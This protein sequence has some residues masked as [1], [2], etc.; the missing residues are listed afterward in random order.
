MAQLFSLIITLL[1]RLVMMAFGTLMIWYSTFYG[2]ILLDPFSRQ[3]IATNHFTQAETNWIAL[4]AV[5]AVGIGLA[6]AGILLL[7]FGLRGLWRR[8]AAGMPSEDERAE[9]T[10]GRIGSAAIFGAG[11]LLGLLRLS[12]LVYAVGDQTVLQWTGVETTAVVERKWRGDWAPPGSDEPPRVAYQL[13]VAFRA[14]DGTTVRQEK[15]VSGVYY[16][17]VEEGSSIPITYASRNPDIS[18]L[19]F[20][21]LRRVLIEAVVWIGLISAGLWGV[22]RNIGSNVGGNA[23]HRPAPEKAPTGT[24]LPPRGDSG[25]SPARR[26]F[27]QRTL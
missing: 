7:V 25:G 6:V 10:T 20:I 11:A 8:I 21:G 22:W 26:Q 2:R 19:Q 1:A 27:G 13:A 17:D 14:Q 12:L 4:S 5:A 9:T 24:R 18:R 23:P 16:R 15:R 3:A